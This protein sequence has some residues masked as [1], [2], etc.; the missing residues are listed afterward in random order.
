MQQYTQHDL[1]LLSKGM[2]LRLIDT[3]KSGGGSI[4]RSRHSIEFQFPPRFPS[5]SR[6]G[7]WTEGNLRGVEPY[8]VFETS[9][10]R[11][12]SMT[13]FYIIDGNFWTGE[14]IHNN[15][16]ALRGYFAKIKNLGSDRDNLVV[17]LK[18]WGQGGKDT[19]TARINSVDVKHGDTLIGV[20][21]TAFPLRTDVAL[22]LRLW[23]KT[24]EDGDEPKTDVPGL[25]VDLP[26]D[27]Y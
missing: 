22:D 6:K 11:I 26:Q 3:T 21:D 24:N 18:M 20:G 12:I 27:W 13:W 23:T 7:N 19:I 2:F 14:K 15:L 25:T 17:E 8:S 16:L 9:G 5:D 1:D 4:F 10:A